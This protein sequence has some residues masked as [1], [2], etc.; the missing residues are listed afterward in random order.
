MLTA[1]LR[2]LVTGADRH[3]LRKRRKVNNF[4]FFKKKKKPIDPVWQYAPR[5]HPQP[6]THSL[7]FETGVSPRGRCLQRKARQSVSASTPWIRS[8]RYYSAIVFSVQGTR[9]YEEWGRVEFGIG[10]S[11]YQIQRFIP[12]NS[13]SMAHSPDRNSH[14]EHRSASVGSIV[15]VDVATRGGLLRGRVAVISSSS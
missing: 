8:C 10:L 4:F 6:C 12:S 7:E 14:H 2:W 13:G 11:G 9:E 15:I 1:H 3:C 5:I